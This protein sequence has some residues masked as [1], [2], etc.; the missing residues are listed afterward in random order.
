MLLLDENQ[1]KRKLNSLISALESQRKFFKKSDSENKVVSRVSFEIPEL[2][3]KRMKPFQDA[4]YVKDAIAI[5]CKNVCPPKETTLKNVS[6]SRHTVIRRIEEISTNIRGEISKLCSDLEFYS[7]AIDESNDIS[8]T[9]QLAVIIRG[10]TKKF[11]VF[12]E[13]LALI[14]MKD[15][16]RGTVFEAL[17]KTVE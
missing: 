8:G 12:E 9:A 11:E 17:K 13:L 4:D 10:V 2:I 6:L 16:T 1:R 15:T 3:A 14:P 5:F 7:L